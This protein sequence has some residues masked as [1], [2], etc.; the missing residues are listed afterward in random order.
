MRASAL[1]PLIRI[2]GGLMVA[3]EKENNTA[4]EEE[5]IS[6]AQIQLILQLYKEF[7]AFTNRYDSVALTQLSKSAGNN[8]IQ[9]ILNWKKTQNGNT[10]SVQDS[11]FK[12]VSFGMVYKLVWK[13]EQDRPATMRMT[14]E[15][16]TRKCFQEYQLYLRTKLSVE[17]AFAK[18]AVQ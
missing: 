2:G 16:F 3:K 5:K 14:D 4:A 8:H 7:P 10:K 13:A 9:L 6:E 1:E 17:Q 15:E 11:L 12:D 18:E